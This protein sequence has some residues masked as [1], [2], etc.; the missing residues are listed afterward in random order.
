MDNI[1]KYIKQHRQEFDVD[2]PNKQKLWD[3][4]EQSV[5][6]KKVIPLWKNRWIQFAAAAAALTGVMVLFLLQHKQPTNTICSIDGVSKEFCRQVNT[7]E[8]DIQQKLSTS[9]RMK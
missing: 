4:I 1:D 2:F 9:T 7:Y 6:R 3:N 8:S 5:T